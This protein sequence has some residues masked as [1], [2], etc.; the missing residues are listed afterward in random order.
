MDFLS[1]GFIFI[2]DADA[3]FAAGRDGVL[4]DAPF[5]GTAVDQFAP[6]DVIGPFQGHNLMGRFQNG[7][8]S[9][10]RGTARMGCHPVDRNG[11]GAAAVAPDDQPVVQWPRLKVEGR[12]R[13]SG[14]PGDQFL[15]IGEHVQGLFIGHPQKPD[16]ALFPSGG[17]QC[18]QG[19]HPDDQARLHIHHTGAV[20]EPVRIHPERVAPRFPGREHRIH[21]AH[22]DH[23]RTA[24]LLVPVAHDHLTGVFHCHPVHHSPGTFQFTGEDGPHCVHPVQLPG[25]AFR[26]DDFL[27]KLQHGLP[28]GMDV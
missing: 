2:P 23:G 22:E 27:P 25:P 19:I 21:V 3:D 1:D 26:I 20:G 18:L 6:G 28:V 5:D 11:D 15:G 14:F 8:P 24:S 17:C 9:L 13:P 10:F 7:R 16:G 12:Q 4:P